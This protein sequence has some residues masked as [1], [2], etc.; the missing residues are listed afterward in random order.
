M[1]KGLSETVTMN[2]G[3]GIPGFGLG[4]FDAKG[5]AVYDA[6]RYAI[7]AGYRH[8]DTATLYG[9]E[10]EV[11][12]AIRESGVAREEIFLTTKLWPTDFDD[13]Q[14][15]FDLSMRKLDC[16]YLDL[17]LLHWPGADEGRRLKAWEFVLDQVDKKNI[18][19]AG[20]SNFLICHL[21]ELKEKTGTIPANN[22]IEFHPWHQQRELCEYCRQ[23]GIVVTAWGPMFHGHLNEEPL[24]PKIGNKYGKSAA[25]AT[26]RWALQKDVVIIP[27]SARQERIIQ[28]A[29]IFDFSLSEE[30]MRAIDALDGKGTYSFDAM[31]FDGDVKA[32]R[33]SRK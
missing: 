7:D 15:A 12:R 6:V 28:N 31:T 32:E 3:Q 13:P 26:L 18:K 33:A 11:G 14:K 29:D 27:K 22:Q 1:I 20:V 21:E 16:G 23:Q 8:I 17:Y 10:K 30:D 5:K 4:V 19:T 25:Q 2:N 9:N 24:M